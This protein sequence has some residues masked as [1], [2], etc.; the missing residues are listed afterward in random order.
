MVRTRIENNDLIEQKLKLSSLTKIDIGKLNGSF[1]NGMDFYT[2]KS[3]FMK[4]YSNH[5]KALLVE[6]I[7]NYHLQGRAKE[8]VGSLDSLDKI[9]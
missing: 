2:F 3:K 5:P 4:V 7:V 8:C 1:E 9:W 6:W